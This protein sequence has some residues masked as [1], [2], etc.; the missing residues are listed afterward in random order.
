M[1]EFSAAA[2]LRCS[3]KP[4]GPP[5]AAYLRESARKLKFAYSN[6]NSQVR[7]LRTYTTQFATRVFS[8]D[9]NRDRNILQV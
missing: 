1:C 9:A 2:A 4:L 7:C 3:S 5:A 6:P 8:L